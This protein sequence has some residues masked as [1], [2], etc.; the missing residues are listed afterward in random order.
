MP[1]DLNDK[2]PAACAIASRIRT[3][4]MIGRCG[5]CPVKYGSFTETFFSATM[6]LPSSSSFT[7]S[8]SRNG[9]RCGRGA[10][11]SL[12]SIS[13]MFFSL[14]TQ[15]GRGSCPRVV[16]VHRPDAG[17][18]ARLQDRGRNEG[19]FGD[20]DVVDNLQMAQDHRC[21]AQ[22]AVAADIGAAGDADAA[23]HRGMR[24]DARV[25]SD[26]D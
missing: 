25:V 23:R 26:L 22:G 8:I 5:K 2:M 21:A 13:F 1:R 10:R 7:R 12:T 11:T 4:G 20:V 16:L 17:V 14:A 9:K 19:P 24:A 3:P 18:G 15:P 6:R